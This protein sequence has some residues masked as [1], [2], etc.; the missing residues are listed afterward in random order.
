LT[1][2]PC[3]V[4]ESWEDAPDDSAAICPSHQQPMDCMRPHGFGLRAWLCPVCDR[5]LTRRS[6]ARFEG[7]PPLPEDPLA[8]LVVLFNYRATQP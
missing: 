1:I 4:G 6:Q 5:E 3:L 8:A 7:M 2:R